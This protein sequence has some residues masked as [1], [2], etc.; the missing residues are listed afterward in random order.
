MN[1]QIQNI[2]R[3]FNHKIKNDQENGSSTTDFLRAVL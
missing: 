2:S 1:G 3:S